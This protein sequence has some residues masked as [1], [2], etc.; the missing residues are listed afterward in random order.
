VI[1]D[2]QTGQAAVCSQGDRVRDAVI[3]RIAPGQVLVQR[4]G[5]QQELL[6]FLEPARGAAAMARP[7]AAS[8]PAAGSPMADSGWAPRILR[9]VNRFRRLIVR[10]EALRYWNE[11]SSDLDLLA[12]YAAG[13]RPVLE[14]DS[15]TGYQLSQ[16]LPGDM[17]AASGLQAGDVIRKIN[18]LQLDSNAK[19]NYFFNEF[20]EN[21]LHA[22]VLEVE[23]SGQST[24]VIFTID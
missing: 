7:L 9:P 24:N 6:R 20:L 1:L 10:E 23:R 12:S 13:F 16:T 8:L 18:S 5:G 3:L 19:V 22:L 15:L 4:P 2:Q 11:V 17:L 14:G 21:R